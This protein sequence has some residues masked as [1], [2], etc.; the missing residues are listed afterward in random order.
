MAIIQRRC[1]R[2]WRGDASWRGASVGDEV[3]DPF[4]GSGTTG[5]AAAALGRF[6]TLIELSPEY[7][8]VARERLGALVVQA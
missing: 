7:V 4:A 8:A 2:L 1:R 5:L 3:L 6:A